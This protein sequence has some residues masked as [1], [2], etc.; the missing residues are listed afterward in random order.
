MAAIASGFPI[1]I[2]I[3]SSEV[4]I[5]TDK[6]VPTEIILLA[7]RFAAITENPHWGIQP[8]NAPANGPAFP[9]L[10][11]IFFVNVPEYCSNASIRINATNRYGS[12]F[13]QSILVSAR[14]SPIIYLHSPRYINSSTSAVPSIPSL[15]AFKRI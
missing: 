13:K 5:K 2:S 12:I 15:P 10:R 3:D 8:N 11:S 6:S 7:Y 4:A 14:I 9:T 1:I